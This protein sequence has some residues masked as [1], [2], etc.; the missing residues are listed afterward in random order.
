[1][2]PSGIE[3]ATLRFVA[4]SLN[5]LRHCVPQ[6]QLYGNLLF[7]DD[8]KKNRVFLGVNLMCVSSTQLSLKC[9]DCVRTARYLIQCTLSVTHVDLLT[10]VELSAVRRFWLVEFSNSRLTASHE[11][12][13]RFVFG[14]VL[15]D[16]LRCP[17]NLT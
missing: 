3:S 12:S 7:S 13:V 15:Y 4:Q 17:P 6:V 2:T 11:C 9:L 16:R 8:R 5:Q 1:M 14:L 10:V